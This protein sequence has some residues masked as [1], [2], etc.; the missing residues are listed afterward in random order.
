MAIS[1]FSKIFEYILLAESA[2]ANF[3]DTDTGIPFSINTNQKDIALSLITAFP[4]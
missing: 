4:F 3:V 2:Y 1:N